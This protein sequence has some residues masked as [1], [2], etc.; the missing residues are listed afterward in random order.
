MTIDEHVITVAI[1]APP[2]KKERQMFG[3]TFER[4]NDE[5]PARHPKSRLQTSLL[6]RSVQMKGSGES[7]EQEKNGKDAKM[8]SNSEF[9]AM[10][11]NK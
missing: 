2:P 10:L 7:K 8:K 6:P 9:R 3:G 1:S 5:E 11:L 4:K